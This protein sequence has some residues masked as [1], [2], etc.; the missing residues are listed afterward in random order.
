MS[1]DAPSSNSTPELAR[2]ENAANLARNGARAHGAPLRLAHPQ[3]VRAVFFDVGFTLLSSKPT[4]PEIARRVCAEV[5]IEADLGCLERQVPAAEAVIKSTVRQ[6]PQAWADNAAV[7]AIWVGYFA[8]LLRPCV[9]KIGEDAFA[10]L[11]ARAVAVFD[12]YASYALYPDA[13][14]VLGTLRGRGYT[15]GV[16]S[17]WGM[18]L[19]PIIAELGLT[20]YFDFA[21][22]SAAVQHAKPH[23]TLF[24]TALRRADAIPDYAVHIGDSYVLDVL[25]ARSVGITPVLL[26][27]PG[28]IDPAV[29]DVPVVRDLYGLLDL[30]EI[31]RPDHAD[32]QA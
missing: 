5:G 8:A 11:V 12:H 7:N 26:D 28:K 9:G 16:V 21:V 24:E 13:L 6:D 27:R 29:V 4:I 19:V 10:A 14:P 18:S 23:P 20:R 2:L 25:G 3:A 32:G 31:P 15:M 30:L 22:V 17:D 1:S